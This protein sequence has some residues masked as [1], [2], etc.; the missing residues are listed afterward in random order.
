MQRVLVTI[1]FIVIVFAID[2][3]VFQG[4]KVVVKKW[5]P[6]YSGLAHFFYWAI[7]IFLLA[8]V[9]ARFI[10]LPSL[11]TLSWLNTTS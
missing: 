5:I 7:P 1:L 2:F 9:I 4:F 3:Y 8:L 10:W 6:A 11:F